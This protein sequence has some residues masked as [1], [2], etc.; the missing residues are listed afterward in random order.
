MVEQVNENGGIKGR[1]IDIAVFD[2]PCSQE[3][4]GI[5]GKISSDDAIAVAIGPMCS[6]SAIAL[7]AFFE[8]ASLP[9]ILPT[10]T[11]PFIT[12][13]GWM[14]RNVYD[15]DF[16][17]RSLAL[18]AKKILN[19]KKVAILHEDGNFGVRMKDS[20][21]QQARQAELDV[22]A[23]EPYKVG[24]TDF[25]KHLQAIREKEPEV[26]LLAAHYE[27]GAMIARQAKRMK[28]NTQFL[29]PD[30]MLH[31]GLIEMGG[32]S[33]EGFLICSACCGLLDL[34]NSRIK[35]FLDQFV[36]RFHQIPNWIAVNAYDAA[37]I[38]IEAM[39]NVGAERSAIREYLARLDSSE[40]AYRGISGP[41]YF[42]EN[43]NCMKPVQ[44]ATVEGGRFKSAPKQLSEIPQ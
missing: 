3:T 26:I 33:V 5:M 25:A 28:L 20:F 1:P 44:I 6:S 10:A 21:S 7:Q 36:D 22:V 11:S 43:G 38:V 19:I 31:P 9:A 32:D 14:F 37:G 27:E 35:G 13:G 17:G 29:A 18:Y 34:D 15:D 4:D 39:K 24:C 12:H 8:G 42:D 41:V 40:K 2:D 23:V 16:Q 30:T